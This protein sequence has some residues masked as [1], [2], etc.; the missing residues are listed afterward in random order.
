[1]S[2]AD[3]V[4]PTEPAEL[5]IL[6]PSGTIV[7]VNEPWLRFARN[8]G[9]PSGWTGIGT[10]YLAV[11]D[12]ADEPIS[13]SVARAIRAAIAGTSSGWATVEVP[14]HSPTEQR[15]YDVAICPRFDDDGRSVGATVAIT[16][17]ADRTM[18]PDANTPPGANI[19][20]GDNAAGQ[21]FGRSHCQVVDH[22]VEEP[23]SP[24][25]APAE[26]G[27]PPVRMASVRDVSAQVAT[28]AQARFAADLLDATADG[29]AVHAV[30]DLRPVWINQ[31][32][33]EL[34]GYSIEDLLHD[35]RAAVDVLGMDTIGPASRPLI[36]GSA[37]AVSLRSALIRRDGTTVPVQ[38]QLVYR[39]RSPGEGF[40]MAVYRDL[41]DQ[42]RALRDHEHVA[43][44]EE[45]Q[46]I[47]RDL[48]DYVIQ[49][50]YATG[51]RLSAALRDVAPPAARERIQSVIS[52]MD[53]TVEHLRATILR[54]ADPRSRAPVRDV[55][56][57][58]TLMVTPAMRHPPTL[59]ITGDPES[60]PPEL[61]DDLV[62]M[63][64]EAVSNSA[65]HA[66]ADNIEIRLTVHG[67]GWDLLIHD[68][69]RGFDPAAP[70]DGLGL[71]NMATRA[72]TLGATLS[73]NSRPG[74]GTDIHLRS[75]PD[76]NS[77]H[78]V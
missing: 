51:M 23:L 58:L 2:L 24:S 44:L 66:D 72:A 27:G 46:R 35:P 40:L 36:D 65:R 70:R 71:S 18:S 62:H 60:L 4:S 75:G 29:M 48:H 28:H 68:D 69:G 38:V 56:A 41:T 55:L 19:Q 15:W 3:A 43:R 22:P 9:A 73:I 76:A 74:A 10:S 37:H 53:T 25:L 34:S 20:P 77:L 57:A 5:A 42:E 26:L 32:L 61:L 13:S 47:A 78:R 1:M 17:L 45:R 11:C 33:A 30:R 59:R 7:A 67:N 54:L 39:E 50:L 52:A 8:N 12:A 31:A 49:N 6:D 16:S 64:T 21:Q 63:I 14:C